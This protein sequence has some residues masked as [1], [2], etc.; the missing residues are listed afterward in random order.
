MYMRMI[1]T[2]D[3][4]TELISNSRKNQIFKDNLIDTIIIIL[5]YYP[6][7]IL[8]LYF[9]YSNE[10]ECSSDDQIINVRE[11]LLIS[12]YINLLWTYYNIF[13]IWK[14][15]SPIE[16]YEINYL[17]VNYFIYHLFYISWI[18]I[19]MISLSNIIEKECNSKLINYLFS[20]IILCYMYYL[21]K[22]INEIF[23]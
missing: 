23:K 20:K 2:Q 11:Y 7:I 21:L 18:M 5:T 4:D 17:F 16:I 10:I 13:L 3:I 8:D 9:G 6:A 19:G 12:G 14:Y 15:N 1:E 22:F